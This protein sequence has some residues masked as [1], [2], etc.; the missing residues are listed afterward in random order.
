MNHII[1]WCWVPW[2]IQ[3]IF[4]FTVPSK[5]MRYSALR[6]FKCFTQLYY[7]IISCHLEFLFNQVTYDTTSTQGSSI[8]SSKKGKLRNLGNTDNVSELKQLR[9]HVKLWKLTKTVTFKV[10]LQ[11]ESFFHGGQ[12]IILKLDISPSLPRRTGLSTRIVG[13][14]KPDVVK[15]EIPLSGNS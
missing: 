2:Y 9:L 10:N 11:F 12:I 14:H 7:V 13:G 6:W 3:H 15:T 8:L 4:L 5:E 1:W